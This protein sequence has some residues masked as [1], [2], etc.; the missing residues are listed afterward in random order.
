MKEIKAFA[1]L[2][3]ALEADIVAIKN[4][5]P[6]DLAELIYKER[7]AQVEKLELSIKA[8]ELIDRAGGLGRMCK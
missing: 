1:D 5:R 4:G 7:H 6:L 2:F 8:R 3:R